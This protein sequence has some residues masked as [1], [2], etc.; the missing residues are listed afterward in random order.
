MV[1]TLLIVGMGSFFGGGMRYLFSRLIQSHV[2]HPLPLGTLVVNVVGCL[3][4]GFLYGCFE[5]SHVSNP[6]I[7]LFLTV[8]FCGGFTTFSTFMNE[9]LQ[10]LKADS[11]IYMALYTA[12]SLF[13]GLLFVWGGYW[14]ARS[15]G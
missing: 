9:N 4:I 5:R 8:G 12:L 1:R 7:R 6:E 14:I 2:S 15:V 10:L 11:F 13:I 3:L